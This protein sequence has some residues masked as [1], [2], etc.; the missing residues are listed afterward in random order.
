M[1]CWRITVQ[2]PDGSRLAPIVSAPDEIDARV[3]A[4]TLAAQLDRHELEV[5][6]DLHQRIGRN[7][8]PGRRDATYV[9]TAEYLHGP[10]D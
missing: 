8:R 1:D 2:R 9:I 3:R 7:A 6:R 4:L 5:D 10:H